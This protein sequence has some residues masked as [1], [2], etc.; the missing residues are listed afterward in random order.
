MSHCSTPGSAFAAGWLG[1]DLCRLQFAV[2][3]RRD[4]KNCGPPLHQ[5]YR[6]RFPIVKFPFAWV[7]RRDD[8][9]VRQA[10]L[11]HDSL[12]L[13]EF[14]VPRRIE[15]E[16][17]SA[18][19]AALVLQD[20]SQTIAAQLDQHAFREHADALHEGEQYLAIEVA[21]PAPH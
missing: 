13:D 16:D 7:G 11:D 19:I 21:I 6:N 9:V 15:S 3:T 8:A 17:R 5:A 14:P 4:G 2:R 18:G 1:P 20:D 10:V 12:R